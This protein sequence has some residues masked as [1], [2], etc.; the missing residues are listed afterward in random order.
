MNAFELLKADHEK[1]SGIFERI[2]ETEEADLA[3]RQNWFARLRNELEIHAHLEESIFYPALKQAADTRDLVF[4]AIEEHQEVKVL[5]T[6]I[7]GMAVDNDEWG[8]RIEDLKD[9]VEHHVEEEENEMFDKARDVLSQEEIEDLG[10]Q[11]VAEKQK[12]IAATA[13]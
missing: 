8:D 6:E 5:I 4:E 10:R 12:Q 2:E 11:M 13:Y 3:M 1:V 9:A 7:E